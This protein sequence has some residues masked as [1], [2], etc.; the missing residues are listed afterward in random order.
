MNI[1][2]RKFGV[3]ASFSRA[4]A[5][6]AISK[7]KN[8]SRRVKRSVYQY[9]SVWLLL[10]DSLAV[11]AGIASRVQYRVDAPGGVGK[12]DHRRSLSDGHEASM[13]APIIFGKH[14]ARVSE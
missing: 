14:T 5:M 13:N 7:T 10:V 2:L 1:L 11:I 6:W 8:D 12:E 9:C 3:L 4:V